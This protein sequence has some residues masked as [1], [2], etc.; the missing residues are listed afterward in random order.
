MDAQPNPAYRA[1][2]TPRTI[3]SRP[4]PAITHDFPDTHV[5][6]VGTPIPPRR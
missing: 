5:P 6:A 3:T 4:G 2:P 1:V